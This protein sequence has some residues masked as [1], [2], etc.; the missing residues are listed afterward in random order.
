MNWLV[1]LLAALPGVAFIIIII[2]YWI[3]SDKDTKDLDEVPHHVD[4][5]ISTSSCHTNERLRNE[6]DA[7]AINSSTIN[8]INM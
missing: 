8:I 2:V 5:M 7:V 6:Q 4:N 1:S 3:Q